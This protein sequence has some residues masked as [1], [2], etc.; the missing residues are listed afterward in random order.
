MQRVKII[1]KNNVITNQADF[2]NLI[3]ANNWIAFHQSA[4]SFGKSVRELTLQ[5]CL[6]QGENIAEAISTREVA[7]GPS[8]IT[9]YTFAADYE[10]EIIDVE[11]EY[12]DLKRIQYGL[13]AQNFGML[14]LAKVQAINEKK[15]EQDLLTAEQF[16]LILSDETMARIERCL[17]NGSLKTAKSLINSLSTIFFSAEDKAKIIAE[18]DA[19]LIKN[20]KI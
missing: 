15:I 8:T 6:S 10:I 2:E 17:Q 4:G 14:I 12:E 11:A 19:F 7:S 18:I 1:N 9:L 16:G 5:E 20:N 13:A 3:E